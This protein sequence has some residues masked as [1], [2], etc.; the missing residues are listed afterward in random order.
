MTHPLTLPVQARRMLPLLLATVVLG[1]GLGCGEDAESPTG[2][3]EPTAP[4]LATGAPA[5]A[6]V[7]VS[8]GAFH[9]CGVT[10]VGQ[11]YC[12]G[13]NSYGQ[14][15]DGTTTHRVVPTA[16]LGGLRFRHVSVGYDHTC[17]ATTE[18][19]VYCWGLNMWGQLGDG[20][21]GGDNWRVRPVAVTGGRRF[22]QVR[23]GWSHTCAITPSD[24]AFCW[25]YNGNGQLGDGTITSAGRATPVRVL[26][27][28]SWQLLTGG[29]EH[30]CGVT[31]TNQ[32]YCWGLND[33]G[34]LGNGTT[35]RRLWPSPV[36]GGRQFRQVDAGSFHTCA[37]TTGDLAYC[38][39]SNRFGGLGD[40]TTAG[41][42]TPGA[43]AGLRRF[44]HV[45]AGDLY[46]CGVTLARRV[47]C[48]GW[49]ESG[50]LGDGTL[51]NR[52]TPVRLGI[53]LDMRLV[54]AG[55][56]HTCGVT[57]DDRAYCWGAGGGRIGDGTTP[58][59]LLPVPVAGPM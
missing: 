30:T 15:G 17:A 59:R 24:V 2:P 27:A 39:G 36:S 33:R 23:A 58:N 16:V 42:L 55:N 32:I 41:R 45:S 38:W 56:W 25:G 50:Q 34:Q 47:F 54:A 4:A 21:K 26:G 40:G 3:Q 52:P 35:T 8:G 18:N 48:W 5:L 10:T 13:G 6:F 44:N 28:L 46:T 22:R 53:S 43:V 7:Q 31:Q 12:W 19:R 29:G 51:V 1:A 14:L 37:V 20:T 57:T 49:N 11:A 9:T